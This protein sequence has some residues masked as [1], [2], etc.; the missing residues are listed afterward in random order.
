MDPNKPRMSA[1]STQFTFVRDPGRQ[2]VQR[3]MAACAPAGTRRSKAGSPPRRSAFSTST[4][5]P[6]DDLV[7]HGGD[8]RFILPSCNHVSGCFWIGA[9]PCWSGPRPRSW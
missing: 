5:G 3:V 1:S 7:L 6:L 8:G 2:R 4:H 9:E